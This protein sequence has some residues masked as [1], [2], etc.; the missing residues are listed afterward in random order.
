MSGHELEVVL[1]PA[2]DL[3]A[4]LAIFTDLFKHLLYDWRP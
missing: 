2:V 4:A 1:Q 3:S